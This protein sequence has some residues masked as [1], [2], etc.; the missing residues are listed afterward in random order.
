MPRF[1]IK[2]PINKNSISLTSEIVCSYMRVFI[3]VSS[4][5]II[6]AR[7]NTLDLR[8][9]DQKLDS[10]KR[11]KEIVSVACVA[12][13]SVR[14]ARPKPRIPFLGLTLLRNQT[15]TLATQ[16]TDTISFLRFVSALIRPNTGHWLTMAAFTLGCYNQEFVCEGLSKI[17]SNF[18]LHLIKIGKLIQ[19]SQENFKRLENHN[20]A[21]RKARHVNQS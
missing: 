18:A 14:F 7:H 13:V 21:L 4:G 17:S 2:H 19:T 20:W 5:C 15:E 11:R 12:S 9:L 8:H 3:V 10:T 6:S 1:V 16:A